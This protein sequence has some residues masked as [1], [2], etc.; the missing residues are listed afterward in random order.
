MY[1]FGQNVI[2]ALQNIGFSMYRDGP[3]CNSVLKAA[4]GIRWREKAGLE[5]VT[6]S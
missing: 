1:A 4:T 3:M 2:L 6:L 5:I